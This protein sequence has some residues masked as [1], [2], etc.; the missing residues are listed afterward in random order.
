MIS[1]DHCNDPDA[2]QFYDTENGWAEDFDCCSDLAKGCPTILDLGCGTGVLAMALARKP[3]CFLVGVDPAAAML[4]LVKQRCGGAS[5]S[6]HPCRD[7]AVAQEEASAKGQRLPGA[8]SR[9]NR[10]KI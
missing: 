9:W 1:S 5:V 6:D 4:A 8:T 3:D 2:L 10:G 7:W